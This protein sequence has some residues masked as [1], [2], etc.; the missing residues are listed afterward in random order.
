MN[1]LTLR[2]IFG[3]TL[4]AFAVRPARSQ[5]AEGVNAEALLERMHAAYANARTY[6]DVDVAKYRNADGSERLNV[7]F[8]IWFARPASFRI[9]AESKTPGGTTPRR[10]VMWTDGAAARTWASDKPVST[11]S[12]IQ[13]VGSGMFGTYAYHVPTLLEASYGGP[14]RLHQ[15]YS[16]TLLPD[17]AVDGVECYHIKGIWQAD[18]YEVWLGKADYLIRKIH[19][20]YSDHELE[21]IHRQI[22]IDQPIPKEVF[23]F[24]PEIE[25]EHVKPKPSPK[26]RR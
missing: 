12:K 3:A 13:I 18:N 15:M 23:R 6:S 19:A 4:V 24:A 2:L 25:A 8:R 11:H 7:D 14:H 26:A 16:P 20:A 22:A 17:E 21:E 1:C 10:E 9:D 5:P